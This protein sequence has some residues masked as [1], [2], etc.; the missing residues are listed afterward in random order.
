MSFTNG[1]FGERFQGGQDGVFEKKCESI[2]EMLE[3]YVKE[4]KKNFKKYDDEGFVCGDGSIRM[5]SFIRKKNGPYKK[6]E[7]KDD[8]RIKDKKMRDWA[9]DFY[10]LDSNASEEALEEKIKEYRAIKKSGNGEKLEKYLLV[11]LNRI[12]APDY[13]VVHA[14]EYDDLANGVDFVVV[15]ADTGIVACGFDS[16]YDKKGGGRYKEKAEKLRKKSERYGSKLKYGFVFENGEMIKKQLTNLPNFFLNMDL[17]DIKKL[18]RNMN[19]TVGEEQKPSGT[20]L[21]TFDKIVLALEEQMND[22]YQNENINL[23]VRGN[24][25]VFEATLGRIKENRARL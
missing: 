8:A 19:Y 1:K 4:I 2:D 12:L 16:V 15:E 21:D 25:K 17:E 13:F 7:V 24:L 3:Y 9:K 14:S 23:K 22:F 5:S 6:E 11:N 10:E 20:E 18:E